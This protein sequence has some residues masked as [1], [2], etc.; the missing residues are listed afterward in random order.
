MT[1][2]EYF[3][4]IDADISG[5]RR[6]LAQAERKTKQTGDK[7]QGSLG[8]I[9]GAIIAAFSVQALIAFSR[10]VIEVRSQFERFEAV[11][12]NT[13]GSKGQ[14]KMIMGEI[15]QMA[16]DTPFQVT[17]LTD[18]FVR[19]TNYGMQPSIEEMKLLGDVSAAVGKSVLQ[20]SEAIADAA[21]GQFERLKEFGIKAAKEGNKVTFTF[22]G[23]ATTVDYTNDAIKEY[24]LSLGE[25][26][27][28][29]GSMQVQMDT[30]G[31]SVSNLGDKFDSLM[32]SIGESSVWKGLIG[33]LGDVV[34]TTEV[35]VNTWDD[36]PTDSLKFWTDNEWSIK[37]LEKAQKDYNEQLRTSAENQA[38]YEAA[39]K[40]GATPMGQMPAP[41]QPFVPV[42][43]VFDLMT[44]DPKTGLPLTKDQRPKVG[45][46][47]PVKLTK[48]QIEA[49]D[50]LRRETVKASVA[51]NDLRITTEQSNRA[52]ENA[53]QR[54]AAGIVGELETGGFQKPRF[55]ASDF[56]FEDAAEELESMQRGDIR[57]VEEMNVD[58][59]KDAVGDEMLD[60]EASALGLADG[61]AHA[62]Q[63]MTNAGDIMA[64]TIAQIIGQMIAQAAAAQLGALAGPLGGLITGGLSMALKGKDLETSRSRTANSIARYN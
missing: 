51:L 43:S 61:L 19:L 41:G 24:L 2:D 44:L 12:G 55:I 58:K 22:K 45:G 59:W 18:A 3:V 33:Y 13:L 49:A 25:L 23:Q 48:E 16:A 64:N 1:V 28:V 53:G 10:Q 57:M 56:K 8:K 60:L 40:A 32:S 27:G 17:E 36:L 46:K 34:E 9:G 29:A 42:S 4:K 11:L 14:A 54:F 31:G 47:K 50:K 52:A 15:K 21:T 5:L 7:M 35:L 6:E 62:A 38:M 26:E 37:Q 39:I 30:L 20:F 63:D